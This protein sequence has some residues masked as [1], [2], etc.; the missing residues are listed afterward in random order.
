MVVLLPEQMAGL[1]AR[2]VIVGVAGL[3]IVKF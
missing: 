3:A 1:A 2:A